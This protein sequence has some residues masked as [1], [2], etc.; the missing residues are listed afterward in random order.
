M[1]INT[2][3]TRGSKSSNHAA[4]AM[5]SYAL[6]IKA[7]RAAQERIIKMACTWLDLICEAG[8]RLFAVLRAST[9]IALS[10]IFAK[11]VCVFTLAASAVTL[12]YAV[13]LR[14]TSKARR[15]R[16]GLE[17]FLTQYGCISI[18]T[19][20][21]RTHARH[22]LYTAPITASECHGFSS[23]AASQLILMVRRQAKSSASS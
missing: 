12:S 20:S 11:T 21:E 8:Q 7:V 13:P 23:S 14:R 22:R 2:G 16:V 4:M 18:A 19:L 6:R 3:N 5:L 17:I 10:A 15:L 9:Q 1:L